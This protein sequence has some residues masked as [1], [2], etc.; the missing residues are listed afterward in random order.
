MKKLITIAI[1]ISM[2][3]SCTAMGAF[4]ENEEK[5]P[6]GIHIIDPETGEYELTYDDNSGITEGDVGTV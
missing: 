6:T 1:T 5:D 2:I 3:I 4:A